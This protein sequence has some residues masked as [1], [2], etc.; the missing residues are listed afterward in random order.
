MPVGL[1]SLA[2]RAILLRRCSVTRHCTLCPCRPQAF[3]SD[4]RQRQLVFP[5]EF[6]SR[7]R[8]QVGA[9]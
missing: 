4:P 9:G 8:W 6:S 1:R 5:A 3:S 2:S 7:D